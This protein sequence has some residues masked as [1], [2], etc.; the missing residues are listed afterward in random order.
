M[1]EQWTIN[2]KTV[3]S[4]ACLVLLTAI[5]CIA[6]V[7]S[8]SAVISGKDEVINQHSVRRLRVEEMRVE[9][10]KRAKAVRSYI[11]T[12]RDKYLGQ[13][14]T[15]RDNLIQE[16]AKLA[17]SAVDA[18]ERQLIE[19]VIAR[20][21]EMQAAWDKLVAL[22]HG[23][24]LVEEIGAEFDKDQA[25][26]AA[27][28][29]AM[30]NLAKWEDDHLARRSA[31]AS[32]AAQRAMVGLWSTALLSVALAFALARFLRGALVDRVGTAVHHAQSSSTELRASAAQ[33][34]S[35]AQELAS[36]TAEISTTIR[37]LLATSRQIAE[38]AQ[39]VVQVAQETGTVATSGDATG[40]RANDAVGAIRT[41]VDLVVGHMLELGRRAQQIGAILDLINELAEQTNIL[42]IN[43][44]IE[45][46]GAG[47]S[48]RRFAVVAD[49]IRRLAD[50][51]GGSAREIRTLI[52]E[53]RAAANTTVMA[54]EDGRKAVD[55]GTRQFADVITAFKDISQ[56][57]A[58]TH[59]AARE[60]E[61]SIRQQTTA[62][63]QVNLAIAGVA[64]A[65]K[66]TE[67]SASETLATAEQLA[68]VSTGL[69]RLIWTKGAA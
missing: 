48:G 12:K 54:T 38:S 26:V 28:D 39:R 15:H 30:V 63:E 42:S 4:F 37:E 5:A 47:E 22:R 43:A 55:A 52:E 17:S 67:K 69:G 64:Q 23:G 29:V 60:I 9:R 35:S 68:T 53:I 19:A 51:V 40:Q 44:T 2:K 14:A 3:L 25:I 45:A 8:L 62:V 65:A 6:G 41:Q 57:V 27:L 11:I 66:E 46:A 13:V 16:G 20:N 36:T 10:E 59:E 61:L 58:V 49:E 1:F 32:A 7:T 24:A 50:R 31:A 56:R 34:A 18:E 33:Q 21:A